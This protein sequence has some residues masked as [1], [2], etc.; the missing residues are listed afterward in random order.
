MGALQMKR[1]LG[2]SVAL[3][4]GS[5]AVASADLPAGGGTYKGFNFETQCQNGTSSGPRGT[6]NTVRQPLSFK[7]SQDR[8]EVVGFTFKTSGVNCG[9]PDGSSHVVSMGNMAIGPQYRFSGST[10]FTTSTSGGTPTPITVTTTA[11]VDGTITGIDGKGAI[12][13]QNTYDRLGVTHTC[14]SFATPWTAGAPQRH[15][16]YPPSTVHQFSCTFQARRPAESFGN[17]FGKPDKIFPEGYVQCSQPVTI[18]SLDMTLIRT[19]YVGTVTRDKLLPNKGGL[20]GGNRLHCGQC[21]NCGDGKFS[22]GAGSRYDSNSGYRTWMR[23]R[24]R[25]VTITVVGPFVKAITGLG[26]PHPTG[27]QPGPSQGF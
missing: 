15:G 19:T 16:P 7:V 22:L 8:T 13:I 25:G 2:V 20:F 6:C 10:S 4:L 26:G 21:G 5:A 11:N 3:L 14:T 18:T 24:V 27:P 17:V 23:A 12:T 9:W 1:I